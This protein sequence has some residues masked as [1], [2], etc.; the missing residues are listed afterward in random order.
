MK[1]NTTTSIRNLFLLIIFW[2]FFFTLL[3]FLIRFSLSLL[4][5]YKNESLSFNM[6]DLFYSIKSGFASGSTAGLG[7]WIFSKIIEK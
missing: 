7:I 2:S 1:K 3:I 6:N 5:F 4:F